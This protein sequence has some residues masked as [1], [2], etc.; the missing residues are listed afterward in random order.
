MHYQHAKWSGDGSMMMM[1]MMPT[2]QTVLC[3][4]HQ[5]HQVLLYA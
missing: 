1:M 5:P 2:A 4:R 3:L